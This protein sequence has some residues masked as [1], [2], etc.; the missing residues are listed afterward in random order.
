[1]HFAS[2][3]DLLFQ[4]SREGHEAARDMLVAAAE[5]AP[6]PTEAL[7]AIMRVF[8][9]WH[10]EHFR[11]ARIVQYE[12]QNLTPEHREA[13]LGLRKEIDSVV[14]D[15]LADGVASGEFTV[16]DVPDTALALLSMA[17]DVA[18]WYDPEIRRT[19]DAIGVTYGEL[20]LRLVT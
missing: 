6:S 20:G 18:R 17:V 3:E 14:R 10:A 7:R 2:K 8:S 5:A 11:V 15:V 19:P 9:R 1:V 4:L 13:V 12:F 16:T